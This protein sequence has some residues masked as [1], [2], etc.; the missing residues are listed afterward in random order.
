M[1]RSR[2]VFVRAILANFGAAKMIVRF[3]NRWLL[4]V[5]IALCFSSLVRGQPFVTPI[6]GTPFDDW[7]IVNYVDI[8]PS[9]GVLD[10]RGGNYSY[11]GHNAIDFTLAN[12][13]AM[14]AGV[15]VYAA[16]P[17]T[18]I[19]T[20]DG[21]FDRCSR[22]I[23]CGNFPNYVGIQHADGVISEYLHLKKNSISVS[24]GQ[25]VAAG[26]QIAEV[27]SS[28]LSSDA[29]LHFAVYEAGLPIETYLDP[30]RWWIDP[31]PY[32]DDVFGSL[33]HGVSN[34]FPSSAELQDRP[35]D[36]DV[37]QQADGPGQLAAL[38]SHLHGIDAGDDLDYYFYRPNG[39]QYAH[40]HYDA[41]Q[42]RYGWWLVGINLPNVPDLGTWNIDFRVNGSTL[43]AESFEVVTLLG[44]LNGDGGVNAGD[45]DR[46]AWAA[47]NDPTNLLYDLNDDG[48]VTFDVGQPNSPNPSDSDVLIYEILQTRYGDLN[49]D[50]EVFLSDLSTF[51]TH[52]RQAG[53][54]GW[55]EGNINGSQEAGT[56]TTPR[57][58]LADLSI[59]ATH[60]RFGV[61][62]GAAATQAVP[63]P[64]G[65]SV[66]LCGAVVALACR[67]RGGARF[68]F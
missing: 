38:W 45:I 30:D 36:H 61:G 43:I 66:A 33:D 42:I 67:T 60:W 4:L 50:G 6:G 63:E 58:F 14:D 52:Y 59:L 15:P 31:V 16:G 68:N 40:F 9:G 54:F 28:G 18:V 3:C 29:H 20:H 53:E 26:Q 17:G 44:D 23:V 49:L 27:G 65:W 5:A 55:A 34:H 11:D 12:F 37:F 48:T 8:N 2:N 35:V 47:Q 24:V 62:T 21:E 46:L 56:S 25:T 7:T 41:P 10:Y 32:A 13:A 19:Y 57:V 64:S 22:V 1:S 51:A 39:S